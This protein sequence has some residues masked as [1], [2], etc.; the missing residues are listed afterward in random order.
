MENCGL[1]IGALGLRFDIQLVGKTWVGGVVEHHSPVSGSMAGVPLS[2][3][4]NPNCSLDAT[5]YC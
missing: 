5:V 2:K 1:Q 3:A 4:P